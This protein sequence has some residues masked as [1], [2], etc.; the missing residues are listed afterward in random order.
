MKYGIA[1]N[2]NLAE[3]EFYSIV[4]EID[5]ETMTATPDQDTLTVFHDPKW[6][7][8]TDEEFLREYEC[9]KSTYKTKH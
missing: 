7:E 4:I 8:L 2:Y 3:R 6:H 1:H 9:F 5:E